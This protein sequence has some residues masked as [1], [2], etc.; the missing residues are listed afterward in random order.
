MAWRTLWSNTS[1]ELSVFGWEGVHS[2]LLS[3]VVVW[4]G[5]YGG[6]HIIF[7]IWRQKPISDCVC[8]CTIVY[9]FADSLSYRCFF[10][11]SLPN[12]L[13]KH[14]CSALMPIADRK[15]STNRQLVLRQIIE[16]VSRDGPFRWTERGWSRSCEC[17]QQGRLLHHDDGQHGFFCYFFESFFDWAPCLLWLVFAIAFSCSRGWND[18]QLL[19]L[20]FVE[21]EDPHCPCV[22]YCFH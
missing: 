8:F 11:P 6:N 22:I 1:L 5:C 18:G 12:K 2:L 7:S 3:L 9:M 15:F 10:S 14:S 4:V 16:V 13:V 21:T 19:T 20:D 17:R